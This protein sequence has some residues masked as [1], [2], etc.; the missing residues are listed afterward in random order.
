MKVF[1]G[2]SPIICCGFMEVLG[3]LKAKN[4]VQKYG[5]KF[6][7]G[8]AAGN[9]KELANAVKRTGFPLV[10]KVLSPRITHKT[11]AGGVKTGIESLQEARKA[12]KAMKKLKGFEAVYVQRQLKGKEIIIGGKTDSQF[13]PAVL[14]GLGGIFV[15]VFKDFS[16]RVCPITLKDADEMV[17]EIK[18][19]AILKGARGEKAVNIPEIKQCILRAS[20]LMMKEKPRELDINPLFADEKEVVAVDARVVK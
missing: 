15:E 11:D 4:L 3:F 12:F 8:S 13:G 9:E 5:I 2:R 6:A 1:I 18:G 14:F 10:M 17:K 16:L 7:A 19:Y 20:R